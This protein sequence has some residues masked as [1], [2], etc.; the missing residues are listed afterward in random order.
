MKKL[1]KRIDSNED[2]GR[3]IFSG[4]VRSREL[5]VFALLSVW[6]NNFESFVHLMNLS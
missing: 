3:D 6:W 2:Y 4:L 5:E 1:E